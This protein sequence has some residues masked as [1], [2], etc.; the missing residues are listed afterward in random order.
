MPVKPLSHIPKTCRKP[1]LTGQHL[2][3]M[4]ASIILWPTGW[5]PEQTRFRLP[6]QSTL[7]GISVRRFLLT[8]HRSFVVP[9]L[10][11]DM[12]NG[13]DPARITAGDDWISN[14]LGGYIR[15]AKA[16][17]SLFILTFDEDDQGWKSGNQILTV[18]TGQRVQAGRYSS[19]IDHYSVLN[20]IENMYGLPYLG[21]SATH[22]IISDCWK[23][24]P[25]TS[26]S[27]NKKSNDI[28]YPNPNNG[29]LYIELSDY[30]NAIAEIYNTNGQLL[31][32]TPVGPS[33]TAISTEEL[34]KGF[35]LVK[36]K[37]RE[38][39]TQGKFVKN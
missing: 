34:A 26:F 5:A 14:N 20:T 10:I 2:D 32:I 29:S 23:E 18:F 6:H 7:F 8:A 33:K 38:G 12:H 4:H 25:V 28:L 15:W 16:N 11:N 30:N 37:S 21:D 36:I 3:I 9:N 31:Q 17:N 24:N 39:V 13:S 1:A 22:T 27:N 35:Y 19:R